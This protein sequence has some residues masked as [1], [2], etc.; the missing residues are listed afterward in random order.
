[1]ILA[2]YEGNELL[3]RLRTLN[4]VAASNAEIEF[5]G[6][7][8]L[9][10]HRAFASRAEVPPRLLHHLELLGAFPGPA[11]TTPTPGSYTVTPFDLTSRVLTIGPPLAGK[12]WVVFNGCCEANGARIG[13]SNG[14]LVPPRR[15]RPPQPPPPAAPLCARLFRAAQS[16]ATAS[17]ERLGARRSTALRGVGWCWTGAAGWGRVARRDALE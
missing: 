1:M 16:A 7:R 17:P 3:A 10:L 5:N 15:R 11:Q 6:T 8:L 2:A 4:S 12:H 14:L 9:L 13:N